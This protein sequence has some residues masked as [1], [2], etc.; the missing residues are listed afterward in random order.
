MKDEG[1]IADEA[2]HELRM[3]LADDER[4]AVPPVSVLKQER[5]RQNGIIALHSI[6]EVSEKKGNLF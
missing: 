2:Y 3:A 1:L 4:D 6:P 5:N